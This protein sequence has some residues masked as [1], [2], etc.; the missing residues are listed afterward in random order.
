[1][2]KHKCFAVDCSRMIDVEYQYCSI[3]CSMYHK[4]QMKSLAFES[5]IQP[6]I[7]KKSIDSTFS[8]NSYYLDNE[9]V[10]YISKQNEILD[11][12]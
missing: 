4:Q 2:N 9:D 5:M 12:L 7:D 11:K 10:H 3:E 8:L 1:M 6:S